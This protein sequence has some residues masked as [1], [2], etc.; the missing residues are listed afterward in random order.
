MRVH[1]QRSRGHVT[2]TFHLG[3]TIRIENNAVNLFMAAVWV[4]IIASPHSSIVKNCVSYPIVL[5]SHIAYSFFF[6]CVVKLYVF[7][8]FISQ[9]LVNSQ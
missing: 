3:I 7:S 6:F 9:T 4:I 5:V 2:D 8:Y 1:Y